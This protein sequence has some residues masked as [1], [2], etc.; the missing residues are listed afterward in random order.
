MRKH[1]IVL[2]FLGVQLQTYG[3]ADTVLNSLENS[4]LYDSLW[5]TQRTVVGN[6]FLKRNRNNFIDSIPVANFRGAVFN[7]QVR[8]RNSLFINAA[9]FN[10]CS[11][12]G[13]ADFMFTDF[14]RG[15]YFESSIFLKG[16]YF[17]STRLV[18]VY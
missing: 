16:A 8:F 11:F 2:L 18:V 3:Q 5:I 14:I 9:M 10:G 12:K 15:V 4:I 7:K 13:G 6:S 17:I 1:L